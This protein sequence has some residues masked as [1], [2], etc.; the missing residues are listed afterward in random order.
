M[1]VLFPHSATIIHILGYGS[2]H[3]IFYYICLLD[4]HE[5]KYKQKGFFEP[6]VTIPK[7]LY[8]LKIRNYLTGY[9]IN[10]KKNIKLVQ[11]KCIIY[12]LTQILSV[13]SIM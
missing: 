13:I 11:H 2:P 7:L 10:I 12:I 1:L 3:E 9:S 8:F 5:Y 4:R 6:F